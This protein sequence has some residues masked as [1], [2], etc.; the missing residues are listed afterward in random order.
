MPNIYGLQQISVPLGKVRKQYREGDHVTVIS[1]KHKGETGSV[2]KISKSIVTIITDNNTNQIQVFLKELG[3]AIPS[4]ASDAIQTKF[5]VFDIVQLDHHTI[6][7]IVKIQNNRY[8]V[9]DQE[10]NA[11]ELGGHL[12]TPYNASRRAVAVDSRGNPLSVGD[13]VKTTHVAGR[14][15]TILHISKTVAFIKSKETLEFAGVFVEKTH[16]LIA[17]TPRAQKAP[18]LDLMQP[19]PHGHIPSQSPAR[20]NDGFA[21]PSLPI[22]NS[23]G[24][25]GSASGRGRGGFRRRDPLIDK[26]VTIRTG[27]FKG[28]LGIVKDVIENLAR[29]ELHTT[30]RIVSVNKDS[31][32]APGMDNEPQSPSDPWT[33]RHQSNSAPGWGGRTP[34]YNRDGGRN[35]SHTPSY[36]NTNRRQ[37]NNFSQPKNNWGSNRTPHRQPEPS[38]QDNSWAEGFAANPPPDTDQSSAWFGSSVSTGASWDNS[39]PADSGWNKSGSEDAKPTND[40]GTP[41]QDKPANSWESPVTTNNKSWDAPA[42]STGDWNAPSKNASGW[43]APVKSTD[44][45]WGTPKQNKPASTWESPVA[46]NNKSWDAPAE[47]SNDWNAPSKDASGWD[48]PVKSTDNAWGTPKQDKPASTWESPAATNN[49]SWDA[50]AESSNDCNAPSKDASGWDAPVKST[51][52]AWGTPKQDKPASTWESPAATNNKSW[53][54]SEKSSNNDS[55]IASNPA[56]ENWDAPTSKDKD[57]AWNSDTTKDN[58]AW[59][60]QSNDDW[61]AKSW[62]SDHSK[63]ASESLWS[64]DNP[65]PMSAPTPGAHGPIVPNTP[66]SLIS[67]TPGGALATLAPLVNNASPEH[68][69]EISPLEEETPSF[70]QGNWFVPELI[71]KIGPN[72]QTGERSIH[73]GK[74][75]RIISVDPQ[76]RTCN[77]APIEIPGSYEANFS[78]ATSIDWACLLPTVPK[79]R[80]RLYVITGDLS[81]EFGVTVGQDTTHHYCRMDV[82]NAL[83]TISSAFLCGAYTLPE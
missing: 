78:E 38:F 60:S 42:E 11:R 7:V 56:E 35:A 28:Y 22:P 12:I 15:G 64:S 8:N 41:K 29:I 79:R 59:D 76:A 31:I 45:A 73:C 81:G 13:Q 67:A 82:N 66:G 77:L 3:E 37:N 20:P 46:T 32:S 25:G 65:Q 9:L 75:G 80:Q 26:T 69:E 43:D 58:S 16:F 70:L 74:D 33:P 55:W 34:Q 27:P 51:D 83:I 10:G 49:K 53:N 4:S 47:S 68:N 44:N 63:N 71:V 5:N 39:V 30:F 48:A 1:G 72:R 57:P 50:P 21:V 19:R 14:Q 18:Q 24:R 52:N 40:W 62:K 23:R 61:E 54:A 2:V 17:L 36:N 6:G